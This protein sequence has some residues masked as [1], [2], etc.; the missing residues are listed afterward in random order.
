[1]P[2]FEIGLTQSEPAWLQIL[3]QERINYRLW[4]KTFTEETPRVLV[5]NHPLTDEE[6]SAFR[7]FVAAGGGI[8]TDF[9][10]LAKL[11][12]DF[13][14]QGLETI[15]Y[16]EP[17]AKP[18]FDG[19]A[20]IDLELP[21]YCSNQGNTGR[22]DNQGAALFCG[23]LG[24]GYCIALPFDVGLALRDQRRAL[25]A[26]YCDT[27]ELPY[28]E[29]AV[30]THQAVRRLCV[31]CLRELHR[32]LKLPYV[33]LWYYPDFKRT[34][35]AFRVDGDFATREQIEKTAELAHRHDLKFSWYLNTKAHRSLMDYFRTLAEHGHDVQFHCHEHKVF[36][37]AEHNRT[38]LSAGL[39]IMNEA[40]FKPS[41]FAGPFGHWNEGLNHVLEES[42]FAYSSEFSLSYDDFPFYPILSERLSKVMQIPLH[43]IGFGRLL[44]A[45]MKHDQIVDYYKSYF[46]LRYLGG[47][48]L[49]I[50]DHPHRIAES[51]DTFDAIFKIVCKASD[52][53][54]PT[55]T[56]FHDWWKDRSALEYEVT[57]GQP[58]IITVDGTCDTGVVLHVID[59]EREALVPMMSRDFEVEDLN[60]QPV[61]RQYPFKPEV[62]KTKKLGRHI[63]LREQVWKAGKLLKH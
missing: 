17:E 30:V 51:F 63:W 45:R 47:E 46:R 3:G 26:F 32:Q 11:M 62:L 53:W 10:N 37:D 6:V 16:I 1:M 31:N 56:G 7:S 29:T 39:A 28:E 19:I 52:V 18:V 14:C 9:A 8:L 35:F 4:D 2:R 34:A 59:G 24:K 49:F 61:K 33:H 15:H 48:P 36:D 21:G 50:Y 54:Y 38:N 13:K 27:P 60:W 44:Q 55:L 40:G 43:P 12:P 57:S 41:G 25:K 20:L 42:G 23:N 5:L 22:L 58:E